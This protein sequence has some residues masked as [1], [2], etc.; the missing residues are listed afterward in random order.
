MY[1]NI[2][3]ILLALL[4]IALIARRDDLPKRIKGF[5]ISIFIIAILFTWGYEWLVES[6]QKRVEP[7][8]LEFKKGNDLI[9]EDHKVNKKTYIYESGTSSL[10]P[11]EGV[12]GKT[13][14]ITQC[15]LPK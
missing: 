13:Y 3:F 7:L 12:V 2:I 8:I 5:T 4:I 15:K 14:A 6:A 11:K 9:C 1:M 10:F